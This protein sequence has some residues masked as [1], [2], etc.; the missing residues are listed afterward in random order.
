M[1][2]EYVK[3]DGKQCGSY[4]IQDSKFCY[5]HSPKMVGKH[6]KRLWRITDVQYDKI[7]LDL[8]DRQE[9]LITSFYILV[10]SKQA[11]ELFDS[12]K[13]EKNASL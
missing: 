9:F 4:V 12:C 1:K 11:V 3:K 8:K 7:F 5:F 6:K 2:C 10:L 13:I